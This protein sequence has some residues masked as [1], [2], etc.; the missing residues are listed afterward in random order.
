[1]HGAATEGCTMNFV[2]ENVPTDYPWPT[3]YM[4]GNATKTFPE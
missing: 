4:Y 2:V 1:M 3:L